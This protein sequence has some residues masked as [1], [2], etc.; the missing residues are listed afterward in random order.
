MLVQVY[1]DTPIVGASIL[2]ATIS[3]ISVHALAVKTMKYGF[4]VLKISINSGSSE[5]DSHLLLSFHNPTIL[6]WNVS[7]FAPIHQS[8]RLRRH[9]SA[10]APTHSTF[11]GSTCQLVTASGGITSLRTG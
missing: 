11:S 3:M 5:G 4:S 8:D 6:A 1:S 7:I 10:R 9:P 2:P